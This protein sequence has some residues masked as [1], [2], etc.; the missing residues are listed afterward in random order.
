[1]TQLESELREAKSRVRELEKDVKRVEKEKE[2]AEARAES[3]E[4]AMTDANMKVRSA[5]AVWCGG[6][7]DVGF[8][9]PV[10]DLTAAILIP[11]LPF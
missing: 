5:G 1:V 10:N 11:H 4:N 3:A 7:K 8:P 6:R 9:S 2:K